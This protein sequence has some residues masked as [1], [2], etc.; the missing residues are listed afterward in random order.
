MIPQRIMMEI[1]LT[2]KPITAERAYEI[3]LVNRL[4]EPEAG[5]YHGMK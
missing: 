4:A 3:G 5:E 2:G 1:I